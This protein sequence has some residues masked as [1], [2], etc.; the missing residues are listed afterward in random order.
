LVKSVSLAPQFPLFFLLYFIERESGIKPSLEHLC[1]EI[2]LEL[3]SRKFFLNLALIAF[4]RKQDDAKGIGT[5]TRSII[6]DD[7][8]KRNFKGIVSPDWKGLQMI[9]LDRFEF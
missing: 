8:V 6:N 4:Q 1:T 2:Q 7:G 9:S 3:I 5:I